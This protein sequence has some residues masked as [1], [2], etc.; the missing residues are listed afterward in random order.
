MPVFTKLRICSYAI[1]AAA[2]IATMSLSAQT[3]DPLVGAWKLS[4]AKSTYSPGPAPKSSTVTFTAAGA[5]VK[6]VIDGVAGTGEKTHWEYTAQYDGK[7]YKVTGNPDG[8]MISM[9]RTS[10][11]V[12]TT[13]NTLA[14]KKT[15]TNTRSVSADGRTL[16]VTNKGTNAKGETVSNVQVFEKMVPVP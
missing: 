2:L 11:R 16:T 9:T 7:D 12:T 5:R 1:V 15:L 3:P 10:A 6:A 13:I 8:D 4:L 14:G